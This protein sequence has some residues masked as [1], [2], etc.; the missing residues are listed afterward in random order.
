MSLKLLAIA[1]LLGCLGQPAF[2]QNAVP[3]IGRMKD[4]PE[5]QELP[6][7]KLDYK[8]VFD[9]RTLAD[10]PGE[11]SPALQSMAALVNTYRHYGVPADHMHL[12]AVFHGP[13][14]VLLTDDVTY[15]N[16]TGVG[17]NPN[18]TL[19]GEL[20][21]VGVKMMVCGQSALAQG[22]N[23]SALA[24]AAQINLSATV[25]FIN[26]QTRGFVKIEE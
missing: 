12:A 19:L 5:A 7:P 9:V 20:R 2:A 23:L 24:K 10:G 14:I 3:S 22:Y 21:R 13:T 15:K 18:A 11:V 17:P 1:A 25:T 8:I 16:R 6:D 26:L 4:I